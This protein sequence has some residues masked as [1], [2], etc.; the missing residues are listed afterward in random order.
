MTWILGTGEERGEHT[1]DENE[2][3]LLL[4]LRGALLGDSIID[5]K[6][7]PK[8][9]GSG[10]FLLFS[11]DLVISCRAR[12]DVLTLFDS[13]CDGLGVKN[14]VNRRGVIGGGFFGL[15]FVDRDVS[16]GGE[17]ISVLLR[18]EETGLSLTILR[19]CCENKSSRRQ[20]KNKGQTIAI[21]RSQ[22]AMPESSETEWSQL[23]TAWKG[24]LAVHS[25]K[26]VL[27]RPPQISE[28]KNDNKTA[29]DQERP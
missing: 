14:F 9:G 15:S 7:F 21:Q 24:D 2:S 22:N 29:L 1:A 25:E 26:S 8:T 28:V 13:L 19:S 20:K 11:P 16:L 6:A 18:A 10:R 5:G 3:F 12:R 27:E 4:V 17:E 23:A